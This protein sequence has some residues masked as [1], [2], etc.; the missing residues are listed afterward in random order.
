LAVQLV[1]LMDCS[2]PSLAK[3]AMARV[4]TTCDWSLLYLATSEPSDDS[5]TPTKAPEA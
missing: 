2:A 5:S 3:V 1:S 4:P